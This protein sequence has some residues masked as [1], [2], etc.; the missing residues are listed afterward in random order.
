MNTIDLVPGCYTVPLGSDPLRWLAQQCV[1][2]C[3]LNPMV[4]LPTRRSVNRFQR[5]LYVL[6]PTLAR[7]AQ[8]IAYEDLSVDP[9][10][11]IAAQRILWEFAN[12]SYI[13]EELFQKR[14]PSLNQRQQIAVALNGVLSEMCI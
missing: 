14:Q 2:T 9:M 3:V 8:V 5:L 11:M 4:I 6:N 10:P 12:R 13:T 7:G 1:D